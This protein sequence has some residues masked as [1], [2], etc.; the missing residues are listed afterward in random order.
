M[1][2][3]VTVTYKSQKETTH[4]IERAKDIQGIGYVGN[5]ATIGA[6]VEIREDGKNTLIVSSLIES[7]TIEVIEELPLPVKSEVTNE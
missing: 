5:V 2:Y 3:T 6:F 4:T 1:K 7:V